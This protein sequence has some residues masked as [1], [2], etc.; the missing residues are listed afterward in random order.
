MA[1][2]VL[3]GV[4]L[5]WLAQKKWPGIAPWGLVVGLLLGAVSGFWE[6]YKLNVRPRG[7]KKPKEPGP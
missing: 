2:S 1:A 7:P 3:V 5:G 4:G 6:L